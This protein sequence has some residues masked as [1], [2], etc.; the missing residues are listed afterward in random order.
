MRSES[1]AFFLGNL[2]YEPKLP[3]RERLPDDLRLLS[4]VSFRGL[5]FAPK[6]KNVIRGFEG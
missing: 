4:V 5:M 1:W 6:L 3:R 2:A